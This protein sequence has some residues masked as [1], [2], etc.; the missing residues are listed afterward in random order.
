MSRLFNGTSDWIALSFSQRHATDI[1]FLPGTAFTIS[2]WVKAA[3]SSGQ[4]CVYTQGRDS[5]NNPIFLVCTGATAGTASKI[6]IGS[7]GDAGSSLALDVSSVA[8]V[9]DSTWHHFAFTADESLNYVLYVDG[10]RD[11]S[12]S[13]TQGGT[14]QDT[15]TIGALNR[16]LSRS[17]F[18]NGRIS[19]LATWR[20]VLSAGD[21]LSLFLG[22][23]PHLK[24]AA[25][26]WP[27][28]EA[29]GNGTGSIVYD[30][31][32]RDP[33]GGLTQGSTYSP[34]DPERMKRPIVDA[35]VTAQ[36]SPILRTGTAA[37]STVSAT[38]SDV[39][40]ASE[41]AV[42]R[43]L[44]IAD[45]V[46]LSSESGSVISL[47]DT[48]KTDSDSG[49]V[50][51]DADTAHVDDFELAGISETESVTT[52]TPTAKTDSDSA[53]VTDAG[54]VTVPVLPSSSDSAALSSTVSIA[55]L[56]DSI[57]TDSDH[58]AISELD[59]LVVLLSSSDS[60]TIAEDDGGSPGGEGAGDGGGTGSGGG[61][62]VT[63]THG[64][65]H[66]HHGPPKGMVTYPHAV[67]GSGSGS[68]GN[69][70]S[71]PALNADF[72]VD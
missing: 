54:S 56:V 45:S 65:I 27:L 11:S 2:G 61:P 17:L 42:S 62:G 3:A 12:G 51:D 63:V 34:D 49:T 46:S 71:D 67:S 59:D 50:T 20:E 7:R 13:W 5:A 69:D 36:R 44:S 26:Y 58:A 22:D 25:H 40:A 68:S 4:L 35:T 48:T 21:I 70:D 66:A 8:V 38:S 18:F 1:L 23:Q 30:L 32:F 53:A 41:G 9:F 57:Y 15:A 64:K 60:G 29:D 24:R 47:T 16:S 10:V 19:R 39:A 6:R 31:G 33:V 72:T 37:P 52:D 55:E 28:N 43:G 14:T